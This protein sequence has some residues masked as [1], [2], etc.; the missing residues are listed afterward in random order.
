MNNTIKKITSIILCFIMI[1]TLFAGCKEKEEKQN[2]KL[3]VITT[4]FPQYDFARQICGDKAEVTLLID[5][6]TEPHTYDPTP[7]DVSEILSCDLFIYTG[8]EMEPWVSSVIKSVGKDVTVLDL[9]KYVELLESEHS[10]GD[11]NHHAV[12]PHYWLNMENVI[13][14]V[15]EISYT[16]Q[17]CDEVNAPIFAERARPLKVH[18]ETLN[19]KF[20]NA[21][22]SSEK[23]IVFGGKFAYHYFVNSYSLKYKTVY[24]T[25]SANVEPSAKRV[26]EITDFIKQNQI[27]YI[28]HEELTDPKTARSIAQ[29]TNATLLEFSTGHNV[30]KEDFEKG[31]TFEQIM[32]KNLENLKKG[33]S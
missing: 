6:G 11:E 5:P 17:K 16:L 4:L 8:D 18:Y 24:D 27:K 23:T 32:E 12:D 7:K 1:A 22:S 20:K 9:S 31:I 28:Y 25:C 2:E 3:K 15:D 13:R 14:M 30:S 33:L 29:S 26:T 21:I 10:H 19:D